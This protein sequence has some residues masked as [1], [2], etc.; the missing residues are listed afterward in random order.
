MSKYLEGESS[1]A[2]GRNYTFTMKAGEDGTQYLLIRE[3]QPAH[4]QPA[5]DLALGFSESLNSLKAG[6]QKAFRFVSRRA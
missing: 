6:F 2:S 4:S 1:M 5:R 3:L